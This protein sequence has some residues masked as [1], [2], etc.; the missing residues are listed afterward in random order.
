MI[1]TPTSAPNE[2]SPGDE[3]P[4]AR[5]AEGRGLGGRVKHLV[6][7]A[8]RVHRRT[9]WIAVPVAVFKKFGDD[10]GGNWAGLIA[11]YGFLSLFPLLLVFTT[12]LAFVVQDDPALQAR[13]LDSALASFPIIGDQIRQNLG[14]LEGSVLALVVGVV[15]ALWAGLGVILTF[16]SAMD[17]I[18]DIPRRSRPNFVKSRLRALLALIAFGVVT[19][20]SAAL[21]AIGG[22]GGSFG[23]ALRVLALLGT[24]IVN[25]AMFGAAF[26]YLT[27]AEVRWR[28]VVPGAVVA[29]IAWMVLLAVGSWLVG[30]QLRRAEE[31]YGLFAFVIGL[32]AWL[33]IG[34][35]LTLLAAEL[36]VVLVRR[37][38]PRSLQPPP[39]TEPDRRVLE[40]QAVEQE[41]LPDEDVD[42]TF[43]PHDGRPS[44]RPSE[45]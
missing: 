37:L 12:I 32:L 4:G 21:A 44:E 8:D 20:T 36:N 6:A 43:A 16:Q 10:R 17:D 24:L 41:A 9:P 18:W 31:L 3:D 2:R 39:L 25:V 1:R 29:A 33:S 5:P 38:W 34:A 22:V 27:V 42:V 28:Q 15:G 40:A 26:R 19:F 23:L 13:L 30:R 14:A 45:R 35:Q 11:Y 7:D